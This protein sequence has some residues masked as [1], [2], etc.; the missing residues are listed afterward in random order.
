[1]AIPLGSEAAYPLQCRTRPEPVLAE[2]QDYLRAESCLCSSRQAWLVVVTV[3]QLDFLPPSGS[4]PALRTVREPPTVLVAFV[5][6]WYQ[7]LAGLHLLQVRV[8]EKASA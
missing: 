7:V 6:R 8:N 5:L 3:P 1:M 2:L 4:R